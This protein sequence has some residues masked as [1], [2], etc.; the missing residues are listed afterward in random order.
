MI[1][2]VEAEKV[3]AALLV[4]EPEVLYWSEHS[5]PTK[6]LLPP[7]RFARVAID[8]ARVYQALG[9]HGLVPEHWIVSREAATSAALAKEL[10]KSPLWMRDHAPGSTSGRGALL[11]RTLDEIRAWLL[12]N[13][14]VPS[15]MFARFLPG[16]NLACLLLY[17]DGRLLHQA[18]YERLEYF[19]ARV[20]ASGVTGNISRG[21]ILNDPMVTAVARSAVETIARETDER[22][23]GM[24]AVDLREDHTGAPQVTEINLRQVAAASAF[25]FVAGANLAEHQ[26]SA[27]MG[28]W[29]EDTPI[30]VHVPPTNL[31]LRDIDGMPIYVEAPRTPLMPPSRNSS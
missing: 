20:A 12:L 31:I 10:G 26:L 25:A 9:P 28:D 19:M 24:V 18:T 29:H 22:L 15:F 2:I 3:D 6:T 17:K 7:P 14:G 11:V 13:P 1:G 21:R 4:P 8:K 27:T 5:L 30:E 16:R 23:S